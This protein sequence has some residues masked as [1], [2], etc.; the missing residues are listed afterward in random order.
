MLHPRTRTVDFDLD[1]LVDSFYRTVRSF[2][3]QQ[4]P[5]VPSY[6]KPLRFARVL[7]ESPYD[8]RLA[9]ARASSGC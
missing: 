5:L 8:G 2:T 6:Q 4:P 3:A 1:G 7:L 9:E